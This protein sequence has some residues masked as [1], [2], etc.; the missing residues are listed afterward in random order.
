MFKLLGNLAGVVV[1]TATLPV[2]VAV[3]VVTFG[4]DGEK[5][6][7][8]ENIQGIGGSLSKLFKD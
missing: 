5:T 4:G 2:S 7:T 6:K 1:K 3:D 8:G